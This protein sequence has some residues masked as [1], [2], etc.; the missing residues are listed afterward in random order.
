MRGIKSRGYIKGVPA[1]PPFWRKMIQFI[2][3]SSYTT[4][5]ALKGLR[6]ELGLV[7][8]RES[9]LIPA[10]RLLANHKLDHFTPERWIIGARPL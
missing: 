1:Y 10:A 4:N 5:V 3:G 8:G 2:I 9:K 7:V 6:S